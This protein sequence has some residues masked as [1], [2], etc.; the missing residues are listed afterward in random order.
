MP[1][2]YVSGSMR[3]DV[4]LP[5]DSNFPFEQWIDEKLAQSRMEYERPRIGFWMDIPNEN[6]PISPYS[7]PLYEL[8]AY[9]GELSVINNERLFTFKLDGKF[10]VKVH[11]DVKEQIDFGK[12]PLLTSVSINGHSH[13]LS[14][15]LS[16]DFKIQSKK[17]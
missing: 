13:P 3:V 11:K 2:V 17:I 10:K 4:Q 9:E 1:F 16:V 6:D 8:D 14:E 5:E 7:I 12:K 15:S